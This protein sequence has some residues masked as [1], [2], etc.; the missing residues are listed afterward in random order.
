MMQQ[1][2]WSRTERFY[3]PGTPSDTAKKRM[4]GLPTIN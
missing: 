2:V 1:Y 4:I 3:L